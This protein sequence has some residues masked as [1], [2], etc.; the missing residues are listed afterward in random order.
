MT[1]RLFGRE[2]TVNELERYRQDA[3]DTISLRFAEDLLSQR[4]F[5]LV[6]AAVRDATSPEVIRSIVTNAGAPPERTD[7]SDSRPPAGSDAVT[8][9]S[10]TAILSEQKLSLSTLDGRHLSATAVLGSLTL[11]LRDLVLTEDLHIRLFTLMG[12]VTILLPDD[13]PVDDGVT[14]ILA[15]HNATRRQPRLP[16]RDR[17]EPTIR[18]DGTALLAEFNLR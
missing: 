11:D 15:E 5:E 14:T 16:G 9:R 13:V 8:E 6:L 4:E 3:L 18:L 1:T 10:V 12:E 7:G 2:H 17:N